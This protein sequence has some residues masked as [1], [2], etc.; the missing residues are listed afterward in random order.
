LSN[1]KYE[2]YINECFDLGGKIAKQII[3]GLTMA[4]WK[5]TICGFIY[6]SEY[7]DPENNIAAET[8]FEKLPEDW[9]CPICG[10]PKSSFKKIKD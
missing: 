10:A 8:P 3:E 4:K 7:G 9:N 6:D 5:C 2:N 1:N